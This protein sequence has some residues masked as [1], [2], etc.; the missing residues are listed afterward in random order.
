MPQ[1]RPSNV[2]FC[3]VD[4]NA[5]IIADALV[6]R[7]RETAAEMETQVN[8]LYRGRKSYELN[9][10]AKLDL[11][12]T[13]KRLRYMAETLREIEKAQAGGVTYLQAAE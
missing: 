5:D 2:G 3:T 1:Q 12:K 11:D 7:L 10:I 4:D 6:R 13:V 8:R 9:A